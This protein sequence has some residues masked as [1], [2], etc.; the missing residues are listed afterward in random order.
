MQPTG[1][2][3]VGMGGMGGGGGGDRTPRPFDENE[4][5]RNP[6]CVPHSF[7]SIFDA[8]HEPNSDGNQRY[9]MRLCTNFQNTG[10]CPFNDNCSFAHGEAELNPKA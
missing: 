3:F 6:R 4:A 1:G 2:G 8:V 5:M 10:V 7:N 9:R